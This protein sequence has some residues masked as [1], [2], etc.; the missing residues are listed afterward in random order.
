MAFSYPVLDYDPI[1]R[2]KVESDH[3]WPESQVVLDS[4]YT[5]R[6]IVSR[7]TRGI[8]VSG[9]VYSDTASE[10]DDPDLAPDEEY[11]NFDSMDL[12]ELES[13]RREVSSRI[14]SLKENVSKGDKSP[15]STG[16]T[17]PHA[18]PVDASDSSD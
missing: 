5:L 18:A 12:E 17:V 11:L 14:S 4:G 10:Y 1:D 7:F 6:E 2:L 15:Q 13:L 8:P 3:I 16:T 9:K